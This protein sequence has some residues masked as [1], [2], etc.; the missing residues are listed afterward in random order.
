[1]C[2]TFKIL[3]LVHLLFLA[4]HTFYQQSV[5]KLLITSDKM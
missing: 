3:E 2:F 1:M 5:D 4:E